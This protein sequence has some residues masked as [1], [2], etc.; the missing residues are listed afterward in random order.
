MSEAIATEKQ[1]LVERLREARVGDERFID[2]HEGEKGSTDHT[3]FDPDGVSGNYGVYAGDRLIEIDVDDGGEAPELPDTFYVET[4]N[5]DVDKGEGHYY[6]K[7]PAGTRHKLDGRYGKENPTPAFGEIRVHNQYVVGPGSSLEDGRRYEI[8]DDREIHE[9]SWYKLRNIIEQAGETPDGVDESQTDLSTTD[10]NR[11][12]SNGEHEPS[13]YDFAERLELAREH[14][15]KL[16]TLFRGNHT[17][18]GYD[19]RSSADCALAA[20]LAFWFEG[21]KHDVRAAMD[22]SRA[23]KWNERNDDSYRSSVLEAVDKCTEYYEPRKDI[24]PQIP[25]DASPDVE[26]SE[27]ENNEDEEYDE[28]NTDVAQDGSENEA[29]RLIERW[30]TDYEDEND[31]TPPASTINSECAQIISA[32]E[33]FAC[34]Y[35]DDELW[36]YNEETGKWRDRGE[37]RARDILVDALDDEYSRRKKNEIIDQI[38]SKVTTKSVLG[39]GVSGRK[40]ATQ[41]GILAL[42]SGDRRQIEPYDFVQAK[43]QT[44][45]DPDADCPRFREFVENSTRTGADLKKLQEYVGYTLLVDEMPYHKTMFVVGPKHSGKSTFISTIARLFPGGAPESAADRSDWRVSAATPQQLTTQFGRAK[46]IDSW[47]NASADIPEEALQDTGTF[48]T[49]VGDDIVEA[50]RKYKDMIT[51][52]PTTKHIFSANQLP[53]IPNADD[54]VWRRVLIVPFPESVPKDER[55]TGLEDELADELPGILNWAL[56]GLQRLLENDGFSGDL[57]EEK[58]REK[59]SMWGTSVMRFQARVL[60]DDPGAEISV[61]EIYNTYKRWCAKNDLMPDGQRSFGHQL[62]KYPHIDSIQTGG[63]RHNERVYTN[64][65]VREEGV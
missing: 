23:E 8:R 12:A 56:E 65:K 64:V 14:D 42:P 34:T 25:E 30:L 51:F 31:D 35:E 13:D 20:K 2:V 44:E 38:K 17:A 22:K 21:D 15:D 6:Y 5:A 50:D 3:Q 58:T 43:L 26:P 27:G 18:A 1:K 52:R 37:E 46:L 57:N 54:A 28:G 63:G 29:V 32:V 19:D 33:D 59:W 47:L 7:V 53:P 24:K 40:I 62:T 45:Y 41:D 10:N 61:S 9:L 49:L 39:M 16:D 36:H 4:P 48:K 11:A 60:R 55:E